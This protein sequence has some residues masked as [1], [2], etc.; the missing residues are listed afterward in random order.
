MQ[1]MSSLF[2]FSCYLCYFY[3]SFAE[4]EPTPVHPVIAAFFATSSCWIALHTSSKQSETAENMFGN[5]DI[6][7]GKVLEEDT[8]TWQGPTKIYRRLDTNN[9]LRFNT[10]YTTQQ[11]MLMPKNDTKE[12]KKN[13]WRKALQRRSTKFRPVTASCGKVL[14]LVGVAAY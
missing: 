12:I 8:H 9:T 10:H 3:T 5:I 7:G 6:L 14:L 11:L 4:W 13:G 2:G 1:R